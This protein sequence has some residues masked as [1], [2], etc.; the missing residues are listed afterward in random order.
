MTYTSIK[1]EIN[2]L[3]HGKGCAC[4]KAKLSTEISKVYADYLVSGKIDLA[5]KTLALRREL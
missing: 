1:K 5:R 2:D 3:K 4:S